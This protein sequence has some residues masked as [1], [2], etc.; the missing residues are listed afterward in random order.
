MYIFINIYIYMYIHTHTLMY[1][2]NGKLA[3][4]HRPTIYVDVDGLACS[5]HYP[6]VYSRQTRG[7]SFLSGASL[8]HHVTVGGGT[9]LG[10]AGLRSLWV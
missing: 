10:V 4:L 7:Q 1:K 8:T 3:P 9:F 2:D 6:M 5:L